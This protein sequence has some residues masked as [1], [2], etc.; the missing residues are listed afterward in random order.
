MDIAELTIGIDEEYQ[1]IDSETRE[2]TSFIS[3]FLDRGPW[4]FVI[5]L[6]PSFS[7]RR[8]KR[9]VMSAAISRE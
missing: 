7:S 9:V 2:L 6:N 5:R 4:F 1:I 8:L 3:E